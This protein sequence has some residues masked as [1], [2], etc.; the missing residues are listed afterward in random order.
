MTKQNVRILII[1][2][3]KNFEFSMERSITGNR[4]LEMSLPAACIFG[5]N[6]LDLVVNTY[7][8]KIQM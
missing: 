4:K 5:M 7:Y 6:I 1:I 3:V 8:K 2:V